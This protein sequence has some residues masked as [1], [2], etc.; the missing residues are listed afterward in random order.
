[1]TVQTVETRR[2][3]K[4]ASNLGR[5]PESVAQVRQWGA[6]LWPSFLIAGVATMIFF[7]NV[8]PA[9]LQ[10]S[11]Y[12]NLQISRKLGYTIGFFMFWGVTAWSSFLT[13]LLLRPAERPRRPFEAVDEKQG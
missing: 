10:E 2:S 9:D 11:T 12:P 4:A 3:E 6:I 1:M 7:A 13:M 8:D 5:S